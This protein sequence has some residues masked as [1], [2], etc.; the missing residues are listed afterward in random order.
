MSISWYRSLRSVSY[1]SFIRR[2]RHCA[3]NVTK[4]LSPMK[5][6]NYFCMLKIVT[7]KFGDPGLWGPISLR[8]PRA[9][10]GVNPGLGSV[11]YAA[12]QDVLS[13]F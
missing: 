11:T 7:R 10:K 8:A 4:N 2:D 1:Y 3:E 13:V 12:I 6:A 9:Y 5:F